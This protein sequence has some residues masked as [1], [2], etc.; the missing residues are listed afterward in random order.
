MRYGTC[1]GGVD[2]RNVAAQHIGQS[3]TT[4]FV[5]HMNQIGASS[6]A[7]QLACNVRC[8]ART[9]GAIRQA[10]R[11]GFRQGNEVFEVLGRKAG[12]GHQN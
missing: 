10:T 3:L 12:V 6:L 8:A 11:L 4:A 1:N 2:Q 7:Q 5:R 9:G